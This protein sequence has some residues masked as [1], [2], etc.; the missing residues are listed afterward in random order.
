MTKINLK[1]CSD[2]LK[3]NDNYLILTHRH[4]DGD[5]LGSAFALHRALSTIGKSSMVR[6]I[7]EFPEKFSFLW[8]GISNSEIAYDKIIAVDIADTKLLGE[9]FE[10]KYG[11]NVFICI[12]HH[13][14]NHHYAE[15][16][17]LEEKAATAEIIYELLGEMGIEIDPKIAGC[18]YVGLATDTGCFTFSNTEPSTHHAAAE[19]M[20]KG[21]DFALINRLMFETKS[22]SYLKLEQMALSTIELHFGGKCAVMTITQEMFSESGSNDSECDGIAS[23]PRKI[24]GVSVGVTIRERTD[25]TY[26]VS[27]RTIEPYDASKICANFGGGGHNRAAGCEFECSLNEVKAN[28]LDKIEAEL[29]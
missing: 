20:E 23:L 9:E 19:M 17:L 6:C 15:Y 8:D 12:D 5:T 11:N 1:K 10:N 14:S 4:P 18:I 28:L 13:L 29:Q 7:D 27:I 26:K 3:N 21:A 24:E 2:L 22:F 16:T 25:G